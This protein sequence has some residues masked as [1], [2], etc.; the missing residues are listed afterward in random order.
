MDIESLLFAGCT[1][2]EVTFNK[3]SIW[4]PNAGMG[5]FVENLF[6]ARDVGGYYYGTFVYT[7][8]NCGQHT[9]SKYGKLNTDMRSAAIYKWRNDF[10]TR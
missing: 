2:A 4:Y 9:E 1:K 6:R 5:I 7:G 8:L 10:M 3:S